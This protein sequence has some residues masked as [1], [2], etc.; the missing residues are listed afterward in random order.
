M[1]KKSCEKEDS[2][3][4]FKDATRENTAITYITVFQW[5]LNIIK[6]TLKI[7]AR[8]TNRMLIDQNLN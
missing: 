4:D 5:H 3:I 7:R 1:N 2:H 6:N 8:L